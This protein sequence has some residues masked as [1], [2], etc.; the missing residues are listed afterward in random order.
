[1]NIREHPNL[2]PNWIDTHANGIVKALQK[3]NFE[4]YLVGGCVRDL[5][6][7]IHP[8]DFDIA[9]TAQ[10]EE[11]RKIIYKAYVIGKRFRLVLV[12]RDD[13]QYEVATFRKNIED[14]TDDDE[15][16]S[17]EG[18]N[19]FGT[20]EEDAM[21]RDFT[22]NGLFYDPVGD[23]LIDHP[24]GLGDLESGVIR[25]IGE[26]NARLVEDPI[27]ILRALRLAHKVQFSIEPSLRAAM[28]CNAETL[29]AT[30]LPR[31]RE[32]I[33]KLL[34]LRD[35]SMAFV[36]AYDLGVMKFLSPTL[37]ETF[38]SADKLKALLHN[39]SNMRSLWLDSESPLE[40]FGHLLLYYLLAEEIFDP[41]KPIKANDILEH[42]KVSNLMKEELGMFKY[43]QA[44]V[45]K[46][47]HMQSVLQKRVDFDRKGQRR[48][49]AVLKNEAFPLALKFAIEN[50]TLESS[51][52][53]F[54]LSRYWDAI[55]VIEDLRR[56]E[57]K[58]RK[59][60]T[61]RRRKRPPG[62]A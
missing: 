62:K 47:I 3:S 54:W 11:I 50:Q 46:A 61:R 38:E 34:K 31:R 10:P 13:Q 60:G 42:P 44:I 8:K 55:P 33:L 30:A 23:K 41:E 24:G 18:D 7:G 27:R 51:D 58:K 26:P 53:N 20:P 12:K 43:E 6:L 35:P 17:P 32:E 4:T 56:D 22:I 25:M 1:M 5:L 28:Q 57:S 16:A 9:T 40:L 52:L 59:S 2:H 37:E 48:Q 29:L 39:L 45:A 21:R 49:M 36:E 15:E 14:K 19:V